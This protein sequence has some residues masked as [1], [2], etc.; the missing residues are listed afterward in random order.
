VPMLEN[1]EVFGS[2]FVHFVL[3]FDYL[4]YLKLIKCTILKDHLKARLESK[5]L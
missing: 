2:Y 3:M 4:F 5:G 1:R